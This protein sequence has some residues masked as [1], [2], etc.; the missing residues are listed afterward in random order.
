MVRL[1]AIYEC[2]H[3]PCLCANRH[4]CHQPP[5]FPPCPILP[6]PPPPPPPPF[7]PPQ[8]LPFKKGDRLVIVAPSKDPNWYKAR[9]DDGLE[10]MIPF[11][12]VQEKTPVGGLPPL[13]PQPRP[14]QP[15]PSVPAADV[16]RPADNDAAMNLSRGAVQLKTMP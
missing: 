15:A 16:M 4:L 5:P 8:D 2:T 3:S 12:Y 7:P 11:N 13:P 1:A 9:R 6:P 10:G 14:A